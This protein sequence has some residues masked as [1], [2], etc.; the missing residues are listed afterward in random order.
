MTRT[1]TD[2]VWTVHMTAP[3][4][5]SPSSSSVRLA[6]SNFYQ[7]SRVVNGWHAILRELLGNACVNKVT[8]SVTPVFFHT[9]GSTVKVCVGVGYDGPLLVSIRSRSGD[10]IRAG[11]C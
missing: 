7:R 11:T 2:S 10:V 8:S 6:K 3:G 1:V 5:N 9:L 4:F